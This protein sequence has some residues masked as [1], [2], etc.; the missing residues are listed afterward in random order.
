MDEFVLHWPAWVNGLLQGIQNKTGIGSTAGSPTEDLARNYVDECDGSRF[1]INHHVA[2]FIFLGLYT[3]TRPGAITSLRWYPSRDGGWVDLEQG[4]IHR[5]GIGETESKKRRPPARL[6][7]R[8]LAHLRRWKRIDDAAREK[9]GPSA[10][11]LLT[12][13]ITFE[14]RPVFKIRR[15]WDSATRLAGL[16]DE[17][18]P[19]ILR[20][21]RATWLMRAKTD[22][23]ESAGHLGMSLDTSMK[24]YG[25]HHPD[26]Q[27]TAAEV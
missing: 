9:A 19:H 14:G 24:V 16:G 6:G 21:T 18:T 7:R 13:V 8:I 3:G 10:A 26:F 20:H 4:I 23:W 22:P 1:R 17:V 11:P 25:H 27:K 2:R 15:G 12:H 5:C